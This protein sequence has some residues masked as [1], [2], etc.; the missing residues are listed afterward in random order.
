MTTEQRQQAVD[1]FFAALGASGSEMTYAD[2]ESGI[3]DGQ[4]REIVDALLG[5]GWRLP[6]RY[7]D[8]NALMDMRWRVGSSVGRTIYGHPNP[9]DDEPDR[10][11][12]LL[13]GMVDTPELARHIA[14]LHNRWL[15]SQ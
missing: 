4:G 6:A 3:V 13:L 8:K 12:A 9:D 2:R 5:A 10:D 11:P 15:N 7:T 1:A 14:V